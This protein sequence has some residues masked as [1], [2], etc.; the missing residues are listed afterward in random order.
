MKSIVGLLEYTVTGAF[1]WLVFLLFVTMVAMGGGWNA[2]L[3]TQAWQSWLENLPSVPPA[4]LQASGIGREMLSL[5]LG[6]A[7]LIAVFSTGLLLDLLAPMVFVTLEIQ[8]ARKW[9]LREARP[10]MERLIR[11]HGELVSS[12]YQALVE[13]TGNLWRPV[14]W[15]V[16]KYRRLC[17]F[18]ISYVLAASKSGLQEDFLDRLKV[19]RV[20]Q[21]ISLSLIVLWG[22]LAAWTYMTWDKRPHL[23]SV[24]VGVVAP[25]VLGA[26]AYLIMRVTFFRLT[27]ALHAA[28]YLAW[29]ASEPEPA[30]GSAPEG[31]VADAKIRNGR[32]LFK[33]KL[34]Q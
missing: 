12:D 17:I 27:I 25:L 11:E 31:S 33:R 23:E 3:A 13:G 20:T 14:P 30:K 32:A 7:L 9:M 26:A 28:A 34:R 24:M 21:A 15:R 10:W 22:L 29:R 5:A 1:V 16:E 6:G 18:L 8:W 19:W 4:M 2:A